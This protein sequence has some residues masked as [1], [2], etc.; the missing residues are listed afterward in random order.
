MYVPRQQPTIL[1][2]YAAEAAFCWARICHSAG[3]G[4]KAPPMPPGTT[5]V[6]PEVRVE[7]RRRLKSTM[8]CASTEY[9]VASACR[10]SLPLVVT[11]TPW[12]GGITI[13][14]PVA[15]ESLEYRLAFDQ[16][17]SATVTW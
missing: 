12:T 13:W 4:G 17:I 15:T 2:G 14:S 5:S 8:A 16:R 1:T 10:V 11:T 9:L 7:V 3:G 6:I